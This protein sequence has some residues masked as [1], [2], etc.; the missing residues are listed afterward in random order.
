MT[1]KKQWQEFASL[2]KEVFAFEAEP[3]SLRC[4]PKEDSANVSGEKKRARICRSILDAAAGQSV[5]IC[6][7]T[8]ACFGAGWHLGFH[9]MDDP[10][11]LAMVKKFVV[12]GEKLFASYEALDNLIGQMQPPPDNSKNCFSLKPMAQEEEEPQLV[13]FVCN[14]EQACRIITFA[15][16][17]DGRIPRIKIGGPTCRMAVMEPLLTGEMNISF[18]D[19]TARKMCN[20]EKDKLLISFPFKHIPRIA[21]NVDA[22][23]AGRAMIEFPPEFRA[24]LKKRLAK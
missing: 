20:M 19:Y 12:E 8:N 9:K 7:E 10:K 21:G 16:F 6:S 24:F 17:F 23:S 22:C 1:Q 11:V 3:V 15:T 5:Q 4:F 13:I 14:P 18:Q 2:F